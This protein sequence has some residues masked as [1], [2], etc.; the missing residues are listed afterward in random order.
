M[1]N[2]NYYAV[3]PAKVRYDKRLKANEKI[4]YSEIS[5]LSNK[6]GECWASNAYFAPL[7][8][9]DPSTISKW[10]TGLE[11]CG[12]VTLKYIYKENSKAV[13]KRI[14]QINE[15]L[16]NINRVLPKEQG[17]YCQ[18]AKENNTSINKEEEEKENIKEKL[19]DENLEKIVDFYENN[20]TAMTPTVYEDIKYY[21]YQDK[22][23]ADLIIACI[24]EA[25]DRNCRFWKYAARTLE[26]CKN[27]NIF[28]AEQFYIR[29]KDFKSKN[30][31]AKKKQAEEKIEYE[32]VIYTEEEYNKMIRDG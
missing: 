32:E 21:L 26:N 14:I 3:I 17:G 15:V 16:S 24:K 12:Y 4:L 28:T 13:E 9:V 7:Y 19:Q 23:H 22:L 18:N 27:N 1:E 20:M 30:K 31:P 11:R 5:A 6:Y 25:V 29:Q 2:P 10:V 8:D